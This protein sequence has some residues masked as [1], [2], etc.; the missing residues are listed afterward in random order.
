MSN[1]PGVSQADTAKAAVP[2]KDIPRKKKKKWL[3]F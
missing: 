2:G 3:L 1:K